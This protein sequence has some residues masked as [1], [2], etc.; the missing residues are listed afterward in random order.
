MNIK[1]YN[2]LNTENEVRFHGNPLLWRQ[3]LSVPRICL[4]AKGSRLLIQLGHVYT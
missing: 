2:S 4:H 1:V 3:T